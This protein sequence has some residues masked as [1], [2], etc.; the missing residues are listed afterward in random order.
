V[1]FPK[2]MFPDKREEAEEEVLH[3]L[4]V[5]ARRMRWHHQFPLGEFYVPVRVGQGKVSLL[6][7]LALGREERGNLCNKGYL[8][9]RARR[10]HVSHPTSDM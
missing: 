1:D 8:G 5:A 3:G 4:L 7:P 2:G 10:T 9:L 6:C